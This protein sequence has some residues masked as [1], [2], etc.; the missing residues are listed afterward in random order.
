MG[1]K[2]KL[3]VNPIWREMGF[4]GRL[5]LINVVATTGRSESEWGEPAGLQGNTAQGDDDDQ[6]RLKPLR[7]PQPQEAKDMRL[8]LGP[9]RYPCCSVKSFCFP[10][11]A[12]ELGAPRDSGQS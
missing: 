8:R 1:L 7:P 3:S 11:I 10:F 12:G 2:C 6:C 9:L 4:P 5:L